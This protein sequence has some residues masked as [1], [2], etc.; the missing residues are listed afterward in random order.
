[1]ANLKSKFFNYSKNENIQKFSNELSPQDYYNSYLGLWYFCLVLTFLAQILSLGSEYAYFQSVFSSSLSG[2]LLIGA[3][4]LFCLFIES[5]K[6]FVFGAFFKEMFLL[7]KASVNPF[8][9]ALSLLISAVSVYASIIGGGSFGIDTAKVVTT[10]SKHDKE[11]QAVRSEIAEIHKRNSW[12]GNTYI[13]GKDKALLHTKESELSKVKQQKESDLQAV[14]TKNKEQETVYRYWFGS[15]E[16]VFV[17][18]TWFVYYF[19]KRT[20][21]EC[22][23]AVQEIDNQENEKPTKIGFSTVPNSTIAPN[24]QVQKVGFQFGSNTPTL[25]V[26]GEGNNLESNTVKVEKEYI[27]LKEN[28]RV[29]KHC[30]KVFT[31]KHWNATYC[32][33]KCKIEAW[34]QRTGKKFNKKK[35]NK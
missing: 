12:K 33:E 21:I 22:T 14:E 7:T 35:G 10:E 17:L 28:E 13:A 15:F 19:K 2:V 9:L 16:L 1:M 20:A 8:L 27:L 25:K 30:S 31:Y 34:E 32:G 6:Y 26:N 3:T 4:V 18:C 11:I 5:A 29:C 24:S 23:Y